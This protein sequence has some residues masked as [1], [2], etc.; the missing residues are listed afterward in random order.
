[1][2]PV[3]VQGVM[4]DESTNNDYN[5]NNPL[6][7][8]QTGAID[9]TT[10]YFTATMPNQ[11]LDPGTGGNADGGG[12]SCGRFPLG[13]LTY[14]TAGYWVPGVYTSPGG[15][16]VPPKRQREYYLGVPGGSCTTATPQYCVEQIPP[17]IH[18]SGGNPLAGTPSQN[19]YAYW[20]CGRK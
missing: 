3:Y 14:D 9:E 6:T 1:G 10:S 4:V 13:G 18:I 7:V 11:G 20:T 5:N 2:D 15:T 19:P 8:D 12:L 17:G 16:F